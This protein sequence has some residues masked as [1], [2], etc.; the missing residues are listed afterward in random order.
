MTADVIPLPADL[1]RVVD[2]PEKLEQTLQRNLRWVVI[3][4]D[5]LGALVIDRGGVEVG[6]LL[7]GIGP[8]RVSQRP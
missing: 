4:A 3:D 7:I 6:D 1:R 2:L 5:H 8:D